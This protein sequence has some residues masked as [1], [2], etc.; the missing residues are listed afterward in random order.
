MKSIEIQCSNCG[1]HF[2]VIPFNEVPDAMYASGCRAT[3]VFYC[4][5]CVRT[6]KD[7]N[8]K[9]FDEQYNNP[10][11]MFEDWWND[12]TEQQCKEADRSLAEKLDRA[13]SAIKDLLTE[14]YG[15][16]CQFCVHNNELEARCGNRAGYGSWCCEH[17]AWNGKVFEEL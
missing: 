16:K 3:G 5:D 1:K 8:G 13:N 14:R 9:E 2:E 17:A 7:R 11:K 15:S 12:T 6:W 10:R 4:S